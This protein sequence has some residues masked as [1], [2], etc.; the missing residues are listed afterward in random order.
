MHNYRRYYVPGGTYF[1]TVNLLERDRTLSVD[2]IGLLRDAVRRVRA[3]HPFAID[4]WVVLPDHLH[5]VWTL[6]VG[7]TDFATRWRLIKL[8]FTKGLPRNE[9]R[10]AVRVQR[11]ERGIWQLRYWEHCIRNDADF[12]RHIDYV[13]L[14][15]LKHGHVQ[16]VC[17]WPHSTFHRDVKRGLYPMDW[18][19]DMSAAD[20]RHHV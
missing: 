13:H 6:P 16:R 4:A 8:L 17:D 14:N 3:S 2:E 12:R 7:D 20:S 10:S 15:P 11:A 1:F 18:A 5:C 19:G 9:R